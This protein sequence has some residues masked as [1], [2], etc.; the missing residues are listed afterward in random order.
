MSVN[1]IFAV[2][3]DNVLFIIER[4]GIAVCHACKSLE[5]KEV[6]I[7]VYYGICA[8]FP[9]T[10]LL[11]YLC[12]GEVRTVAFLPSFILKTRVWIFFD[13]PEAES[14]SYMRLKPF[15]T[16]V[17]G[18]LTSDDWLP[19]HRTGLF[20]PYE[21]VEVIDMLQGYIIKGLELAESFKCFGC[22]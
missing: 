17:D 2:N 18:C 21:K 3:G 15:V 7:P 11:F 10:D 12:F 9:H 8:F 19:F 16:V 6:K 13:K 22:G 1:V 20:F 14:F 5:E 4:F